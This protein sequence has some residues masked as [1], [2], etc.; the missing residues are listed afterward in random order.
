MSGKE[1]ATI[2]TLTA[3]VKTMMLNSRQITLTILKQLD[4][5][6]V[7]DVEPFG[8]VNPVGSGADVVHIVGRHKSTGELVRAQA[9]A[10]WSATLQHL[11]LTKLQKDMDQ[12]ISEVTDAASEFAGPDDWTDTLGARAS[13]LVQKMHDATA[14]YVAT[15]EQLNALP[16]I[17]LA[18][19][20]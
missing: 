14:P 12:A 18:G 19:L 13:A 4:T 20:A 5:V 10:T 16:L 15:A 1:T 2:V 8:R 7:A 11:G 6:D 9:P 17:V 3:S